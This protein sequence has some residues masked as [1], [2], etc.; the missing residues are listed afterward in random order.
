M[1]QQDPTK[2][3]GTLIIATL[4]STL[5]KQSILFRHPLSPRL[6][7]LS[8]ISDQAVR[9]YSLLS[10]HPTAHGCSNKT[11]NFRMRDVDSISETRRTNGKIARLVPPR[12]RL[13]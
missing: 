8:D 10:S 9:K 11:A 5:T 2:F 6:R 7:K 3:L 4:A 1:L 12:M 13:S